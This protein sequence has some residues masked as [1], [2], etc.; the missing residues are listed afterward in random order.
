MSG[1][2]LVAGLGNP[3]AKYE[4]TRHNAGFWFLDSLEKDAGPLELKANRKLHGEASKRSFSGVDCVFLRPD[5]FMNDS[6]R[7]VRATADYFEVAAERIVVAYDDLDLQ[8]GQVKLKLGGGHGGHNGLRSIFAHLGSHDFWRL[9][10]GIGHPGMREQVTPWVLG[11]AGVDDEKAILDA[12]DRGAGVLPEL[13][14]GDAG[15]AMKR[16]HSLGSVVGGRWSVVGG[17]WS[18]VG[19]SVVG[20]R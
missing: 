14:R 20:S 16:L 3:G 2:W 7:A 8:P 17:R 18:V 6:G 19:R 15:E 12:V 9:R 5:T 1:R 11:R 13:L 10:I 4:R